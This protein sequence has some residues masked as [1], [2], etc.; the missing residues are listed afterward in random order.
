MISFETDKTGKAIELYLDSNGIDELIGY[1]NY[2]RREKDHFHLTIGN[3]LKQES[4]NPKNTPVE[5]VNILHY[6]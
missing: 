1:L 4:V 2:I 5:F 3:E 6:H